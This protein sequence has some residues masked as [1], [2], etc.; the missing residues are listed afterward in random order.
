MVMAGISARAEN[1]E[2]VLSGLISRVSR[3]REEG[4][5]VVVATVKT[6]AH[7]TGTRR[8][9]RQRNLRFLSFGTETLISSIAA[10]QEP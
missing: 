10:A 7:S 5:E 8:R 1:D 9:R 4:H 3:G 2:R 6:T